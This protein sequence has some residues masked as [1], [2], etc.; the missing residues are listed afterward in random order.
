MTVEPKPLQ[1]THSALPTP[2]ALQDAAHSPGRRKARYG[3]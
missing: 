2:D 1:D 3:W